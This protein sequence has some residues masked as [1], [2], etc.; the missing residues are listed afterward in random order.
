LI[1]VIQEYV[2]E[3]KAFSDFGSGEQM[4]I[5]TLQQARYYQV[6]YH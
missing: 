1:F 6:I 4:A 3:E 2:H 5:A